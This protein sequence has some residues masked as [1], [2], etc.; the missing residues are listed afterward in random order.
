M[1]VSIASDGAQADSA[2]RFPA[3]SKDGRYVTFFSSATDLVSG[4]TNALNDIFVHDR[5]SGATTRVS[6]SSDGTQGNGN[7]FSPALSSDGRYVAFYSDATNLVS[8]DTD[9]FRDI[10]VVPVK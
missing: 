1:R 9:G 7:S 5:Q 3:I 6:V 4:D 10:F 8:G 2:S